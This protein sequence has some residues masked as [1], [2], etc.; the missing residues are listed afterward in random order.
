MSYGTRIDVSWNAVAEATSYAGSLT[1]SD[2]TIPFTVSSA[3]NQY[4]FTGFTS[5][6]AHTVTVEAI[7]AEGSASSTKAVDDISVGMCWWIDAVD[8]SKCTIGSTR[9]ISSLIKYNTITQINDKSGAGKNATVVTAA[10]PDNITFNAPIYM[11]NIP[12]ATAN[13]ATIAAYAPIAINYEVNATF[14]APSFLF[15]G[16]S[17]PGA[18]ANDSMHA[19]IAQPSLG[20]PFAFFA[21]N[22]QIAE[23]SLYGSADNADYYINYAGN[24]LECDLPRFRTGGI[25]AT[26]YN[27]VIQGLYNATITGSDKFYRGRI[28]GYQISETPTSNYFGFNDF[29]VCGRPNYSPSSYVSECIMYNRLLTP[30]EVNMLEGYLGWKYGITLVSTHPYYSTP[31]TGS[32]ITSAG[33]SSYAAVVPYTA[34]DAINQLFTNSINSYMFNYSGL[35]GD[36]SSLIQFRSILKPLSL[37]Q[38]SLGKIN[39][40]NVLNTGT[41]QFITISDPSDVANYIYTMDT[42]NIDRPPLIS[43][44][45]NVLLPVYTTASSPYTASFDLRNRLNGVRITDILQNSI[46]TVVFELPISIPGGPQYQ[47]TLSNFPG[48]IT[49]TYNGTVLTDVNTGITYNASNTLTVGTLSIP[50]VGLGSIGG[51]GGGGGGGGG[52]G[53]GFVAPSATATAGTESI[54][55]NW[56]SVADGFTIVDQYNVIY[57]DTTTGQST[58]VI[59]PRAP[60]DIGTGGGYAYTITIPGLVGGRS[61]TVSVAAHSTLN[62]VSVGPATTISGLVPSSSGGGGGGGGG[63]GAGGGNGSIGSGGAIVSTLPRPANV[64]SFTPYITGYVDYTSPKNTIYG[65]WDSK[66]RFIFNQDLS[67]EYISPASLPNFPI[68]QGGNGSQIVANT[69]NRTLFNALNAQTNQVNNNQ[70]SWAGPVFKSHQDLMRYIQAQYTQPLP[71]T[72][73]AGTNYNIGTLFPR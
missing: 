26:N 55:L 46:A 29:R 69:G 72:P 59:V 40:I 36:I 49:L 47:L 62:V 9:N 63:G 52:G 21:V 68:R 48:S 19:T 66:G 15:R 24:Y 39:T 11:P 70:R 20:T 31:F 44:P 43:K 64:T 65:F 73:Q 37:S 10:P 34:T 8:I 2:G 38:K 53:T 56:I 7:N 60:G 67:G 23:A 28:N 18:S 17:N 25:S 71:G 45:I 58:T 6:V 4:V 16:N 13:S 14:N 61:Y 30:N 42:I 22:K 5:G 50:L 27:F 12:L 35:V 33:T 1:G 51:Y 32:V 41:Q 3:I 54:T 57:T